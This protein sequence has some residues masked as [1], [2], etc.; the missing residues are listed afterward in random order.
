MK[1]QDVEVGT[2]GTSTNVADLIDLRKVLGYQT[3][4]VYGV[5]YGAL[6]AQVAMRRDPQGIRS[7]VL[8]SPGMLDPAVAAERALSTE[9]AFDRVLQGCSAQPSCRAAFPALDEDLAAVYTALN[10]TPIDVQLERGGAPTT[11]SIDGE[12]LLRQLTAWLMT[13][14]RI[15]QVPALLSELRRGDRMRAARLLLGTRGDLTPLD[16]LPALVICHDI[17][18]EE[19][20]ASTESVRS[21]LRPMFRG[22]TNDLADCKVWQT[23]LADPSE[24]TPVQSGIP[25]LI[26]TGEFDPLVRPE[27]AR[28]LTTT[29]PRARWYELAGEGHGSPPT[30]CKASIMLQFLENP[31]REPDASCV[32]AA[33][34]LTFAA[35]LP[36][37]TLALVITATGRPY[38]R[39]AGEWQAE[40]A[41]QTTI[42]LNVA[43]PTLT[44]TILYVIPAQ[45]GTTD[46]YDGRIDDTTMTFKVKSPSGD[47]TITFTATLIATD[48]MRFQRDV[49]VAAGGAAGGAGIFGALGART[50]T[51]KRVQ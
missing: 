9:R 50:F 3:W 11:V 10:E 27:H 19:Y 7:V 48:E 22:L 26:L 35:R 20:R 32:A 37:P 33:P 38:E 42:L 46:I 40:F 17:Y 14:Q 29:L 12:R 6:L 1:A 34:R 39:F 28:K 15:A 18:G 45:S 41:G 49:E 24:R 51:A 16:P 30:G 25:A 36:E 2:F 31:T 5:S 21:R 47:R 43:G 8:D 13:P 4:D 44:G 23:A